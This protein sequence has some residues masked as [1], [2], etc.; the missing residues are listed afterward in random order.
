M[1]EDN[2]HLCFECG[3]MC[4]VCPCFERALIAGRIEHA[5]EEA[6]RLAKPAPVIAKAISDLLDITE[7][8]SLINGARLLRDWLIN[9]PTPLDTHHI[10]WLQHYLDYTAL[11]GIVGVKAEPYGAT[12]DTP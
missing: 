3:E 4:R 11:R 1:G 12:G 6:N 9:Q 10:A 5:R 2:L 7:R 8:N